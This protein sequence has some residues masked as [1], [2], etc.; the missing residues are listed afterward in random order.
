MASSEQWHG[1]VAAGVAPVVVISACALMA[2]AFY[3]RLASIISRLRGFQ[4]ERLAEQE[5]IHQLGGA[6]RPDE[7]LLHRRHRVLANLA[8]QTRRTLRRAKLI[9]M[10]LLCLLGT[11]GLLVISSILNGVSVVWPEARTGAVV[12]FLFGMSLL[13]VA[14]VCAMAELLSVLDVVESETRLVNELAG[15]SAVAPTLP[16]AVAGP[17]KRGN[18]RP[19]S[20]PLNL[21]NHG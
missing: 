15:T 4:R 18:D 7:F 6:D 10:T 12:L 14:I 9:R 1:I 2:L 20:T 13:L 19:V 17:R 21:H 8:E 16:G 5:H 3:N 11:I